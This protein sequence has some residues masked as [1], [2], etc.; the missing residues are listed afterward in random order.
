MSTGGGAKFIDLITI[1][2]RP[3]TDTLTCGNEAK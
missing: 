2:Y 1:N 3:L